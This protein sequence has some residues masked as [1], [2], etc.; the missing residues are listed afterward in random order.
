MLIESWER[1]REALL[2][3]V[4]ERSGSIP[5]LLERSDVSRQL[6]VPIREYLE[7]ITIVKKSSGKLGALERTRFAKFW[8]LNTLRPS[9][10]LRERFFKL[11]ESEYSIRHGD[12]NKIMLELKPLARNAY[13]FSH[14]TKLLHSVDPNLPIIDSKVTKFFCLPSLP[15]QYKN[16]DRGRWYSERYNLLIVAY[17][18][19]GSSREIKMTFQNIESLIPDFAKLS[20][21]KKIDSVITDV[22]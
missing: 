13:L 2:K 10:D 4:L 5:E 8:A 12:V 7:L 19:L 20:F 11:L 9:Y 16:L 17:Q 1:E 6:Q 15:Y 21:A 3:R 22:L 14:A 18:I